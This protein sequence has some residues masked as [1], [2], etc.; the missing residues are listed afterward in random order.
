[1]EVA[2]DDL[3]IVAVFLKLTLNV[4]VLCDLISV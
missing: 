1:M 4:R 3:I 2:V